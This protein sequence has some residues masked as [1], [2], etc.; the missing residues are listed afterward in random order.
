MCP[1]SSGPLVSLLGIRRHLFTALAMAVAAY[2][3]MTG[4]NAQVDQIDGAWAQIESNAGACPGCRISFDQGNAS[5]AVTANNGWTAR[6]S[7]RPNGDTT[8]ATGVGRWDSGLTGGFAG[9]PFE[10]DFAVMD[11]RLYMSMVVDMKNGSKRVI[12]GVYGRIWFG[13]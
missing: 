10:I 5:W 2:A 8:K 9:K 11:Q 3:S 1:A 4:A 6:V 13:A 7:A 12:R